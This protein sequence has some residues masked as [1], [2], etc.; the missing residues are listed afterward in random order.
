MKIYIPLKIKHSYLDLCI[1]SIEKYKNN[2]ILINQTSLNNKEL[3]YLEVEVV[4]PPSM[5]KFTSVMN[6]I[7]KDA[8]NRNL[9]YYIW[10]HSDCELKNDVIPELIDAFKKDKIDIFLPS[11]D[12]ISITNIDVA[13]SIHWDEHFNWYY[14]DN[15][16]Y[17]MAN[18]LGFNIRY[19][20]SYEGIIHHV[21]QTLKHMESYEKS[22]FDIKNAKDSI[23]YSKKWG[24]SPQNE[25]YLRP[26]NRITLKK[27]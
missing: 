11:Y 17:R 10:M 1:K 25:K 5:A 26:Y 19:S 20:M 4:N 21:S 7:Q 8:I 2:I 22:Q 12:A 9:E 27:E 16:F 24:G 15:D 3:D 13:K 18:I 23:L 14:S 6:W